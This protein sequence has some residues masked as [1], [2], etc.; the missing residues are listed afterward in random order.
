MR[1]V[2]VG[3]FD[4]LDCVVLGGGT[5]CQSV[6]LREDVPHPVRT[7]PAGRDLRERVCLLVHLRL[8]EAAQVVR[9]GFVRIWHDMTSPLPKF[10]LTQEVGRSSWSRWSSIAGVSLELPRAK[11]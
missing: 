7:L 10:W 8:H 6:E 2:R 1:E 5:E 3:L 9:V 4:A 11:S